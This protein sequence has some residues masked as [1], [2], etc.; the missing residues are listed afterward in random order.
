MDVFLDMTSETA[1]SLL[2]AAHSHV[3]QLLFSQCYPNRNELQINSKLIKR[4]KNVILNVLLHQAKDRSPVR[5]M[6]V[7]Q[8]L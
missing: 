4:V 3:Q 6:W 7:A 1:S 2:R 5:T 8:T